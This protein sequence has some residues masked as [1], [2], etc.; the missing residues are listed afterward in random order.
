[1]ILSYL[2]EKFAKDDSLY[3]KDPETRALVNHR[4]YFDL[5]TLYQKF[6]DWVIE[7]VYTKQDNPDKFKKILDA[8]ELFN[9]LL[10]GNEFAVGN[11]VTIADYTLV[12]SISTLEGIGVDL[13]KY[14]NVMRWYQKCK[15]IIP[16]YE[17]NEKGLEAFK[18][19]MKK[20]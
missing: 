10:K 13:S 7:K 3:P 19:M 11:Q 17:I 5:G 2:V 16:N 15:K 6:Y 14:P 1:M 20:Y 9:T 4:M 12:A 18:E 8:V